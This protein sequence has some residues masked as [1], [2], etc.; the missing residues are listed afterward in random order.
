ME[1]EKSF[2]EFIAKIDLEI[3]RLTKAREHLYKGE[4]Y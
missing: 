2:D 4:V 3:E 1:I